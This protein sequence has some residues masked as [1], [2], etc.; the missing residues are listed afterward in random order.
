VPFGEYLPFAPLLN[1]LGIKQFVTTFKGWSAGESRNLMQTDTTPPFLPLI[2]YEAIFS[3]AIFSGIE[4]AVANEAQF[5]LNLT[6]DAWFDNSIGPAQHFQHARLR[7]VEQGLPMV[8]VAN[9]GKS[10]V[11]GPLGRLSFVMEPGEI[12]VVDA[13]LPNR[14]EATFFSRYLNLPFFGAL[15]SGF[16]LL[17]FTRLRRKEP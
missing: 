14:I 11:I 15:L 10:A 2:C 5:I 16:A 9:T 13:T 7:A 4:G 12:G 17:F 3:G 1:S 8:R 6:N